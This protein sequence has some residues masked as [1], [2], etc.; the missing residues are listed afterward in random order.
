MHGADV[1]QIVRN[2]AGQEC[3]KI[4][5]ESK[6]TKTFGPD[7]I[8]KLKNDQREQKADMAV[9][10]SENLPKDMDRFGNKERVWICTF[11]EVK[12]L[13]FVLREMLIKVH[14]VGT[15]E[16]NKTDKMS[17]LYSYLTSPEFSERIEAIV[18]GFSD[19]KSG[20]D[21]EKRAM[22]KIWKQREKQIE[23]VTNNTIDMYGSIKGIAGKA[24]GTVKALELP[25][26]E[27]D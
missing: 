19:M 17:L 2:D 4:I 8:G 21:S 27:S 23:K 7:W 10:V 5:Y 6:R 1:I 18:E 15:S 26:P 20:I 3:G 12:G 22:Q 9:I 24:I 11:P 25:E 13:S 14:A 16:E